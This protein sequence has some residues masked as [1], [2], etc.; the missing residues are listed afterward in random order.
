MDVV[1]VVGVAED[2]AAASGDAERAPM[3]AGVVED[4]V[5]FPSSVNLN[6]QRRCWL[7]TG[8]TSAAFGLWT[9]RQLGIRWASIRAGQGSASGSGERQ[10]RGLHRSLSRRCT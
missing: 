9:S 2:L 7:P 1:D 10:V 6:P 3:E 8:R 4:R 5:A